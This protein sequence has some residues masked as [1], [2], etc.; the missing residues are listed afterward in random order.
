MAAWAPPPSPPP[1]LPAPTREPNSADYAPGCTRDAH[2]PASTLPSFLWASLPQPRASPQQLK[3]QRCDGEDEWW[4]QQQ[5]QQ[6][7]ELLEQNPSL[8]P[9]G[10]AQEPPTQ[11]RRIDAGPAYAPPF[12][13]PQPAAPLPSPLQAQQQQQQPQQPETGDL[14]LD[15][16]EAASDWE[17]DERCAQPPPAQRQRTEGPEFRLVL[18]AR[19]LPCIPEALRAA[20]R[21][22][23]A[24]PPALAQPGGDAWA[25]VP[26]SPPLVSAAD[27]EGRQQQQEQAKVRL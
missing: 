16:A 22:P 10:A 25:V 18:P 20:P 5:Q 2:I 6:R 12:P 8:A 19:L 17:Q 21:P 11:R 24:Q 14:D 9:W 26:W 13:T 4:Q 1:T 15:I 7:N 3:R 23:W 27:L